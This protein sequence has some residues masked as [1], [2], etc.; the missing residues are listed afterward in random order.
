MRAVI[1]DMSDMTD[2]RE[3]LEARTHPAITTFIILLILIIGAGLTWSFFGEIDEVA[4]ASGIIRPN[5]K[6]SNI[7]SPVM[8]TLESFHVKEG[9]WVEAGDLLMSL[10]HE[11][12]QLELLTYKDQFSQLEQDVAFLTRYRDSIESHSNLFDKKLEDEKVYYHL[13]EQYLLEYAQKK[14]QYDT[15]IKQVE[16]ATGESQLAKEGVS[17][18]QQAATKKNNQAIADYNRKIEELEKELSGE[19]Q[20]KLSMEKENNK[21]PASDLLRTDRFNQYMLSL[22]ELKAAVSESEKKVEQSIALGERFVSASQLEK[23]ELQVESAKL[24]LTQFQQDALLGVQA[25]IT[26]YENKLVETQRLLSQLSGKDSLVS[27]EH[28]TLELEEEKLRDQY[29]NLQQQSDS[30]REQS[31][32]ELE[33]FRLDR[34]V[35]IEASIEE[36]EAAVQLLRSQIDQLQLSIDKQSIHA[37]ISGMVHMMKELNMGDIVQ[38]GESLLSVIPVNESMYKISIAVPNHEI[39]QIALGQ[40]VDMNFHAFPKQSF[41]S[42]VGTVQSISTDSIVQQDG[43]S[44]YTVEASISNTPLVNRKGESGE[45]RVGMTAEAYVITDS[46]KIIHF[47]LEKINLRD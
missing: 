10:E 32:I 17:L 18:N 25:Q 20:L 39:G 16:Q 12:L 47:L 24:Q 35:H 4:K 45:I 15:N 13:V 8:G 21:L 14:L 29:N 31:T 27:L 3:I 36:K 33:K 44:Y 5:E 46:K 34:L 1:R 40:E 41:G 9:Q 38:P 28:Q 22:N 30:V 19:K 6:V 23:E 2:S 42:L 7:Q 26:D 43:R 11:S 37:P